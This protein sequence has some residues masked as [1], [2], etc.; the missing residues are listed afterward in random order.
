MFCQL[1]LLLSIHI[2]LVFMYFGVFVV[3]GEPQIPCYFIFGDSL[4]DSGNNNQL[5]TTT[6]AN[7]PSYGID[8]PQGVTGRFTNG[9]T[10]DD[11]IG[12]SLTR[13]HYLISFIQKRT[14]YRN[15]F[16]HCR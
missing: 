15:C 9:R 7:Y 3:I 2:F 12:I 8:F 11:I 16:L 5:V 6:K 13:F 1:N 10:I 4:V 14:K